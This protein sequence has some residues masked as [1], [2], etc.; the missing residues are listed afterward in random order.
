MDLSQAHRRIAVA[1]DLT[2]A[3]WRKS[4]Y[5]QGGSANCV[6]VGSAGNAVGVRDT[7]NREIGALAVTSETFAAFVNAVTH[8]RLTK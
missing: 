1:L 7:K 8:N 6:E 4:T 2:E 5:S 3:A